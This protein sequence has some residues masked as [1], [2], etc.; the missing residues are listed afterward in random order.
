MIKKEWQAILKNK[1]FIGIMI[2][3]AFI[4]ALYNIIFLSSMW[5]PYGKIQD[6][7]VAVINLDK[8]ATLNGKTV[9]LGDDLV[10]KLAKNKA[11]DYH[12]VSEEKATS[13]IKSG[14]YFM[15]ITLPSDFSKN[16]TTLLD[17]SAKPAKIAYQT[18]KGHN[19]ISAKMSESAMEKLKAEVASNVTATYTSEIFDKFGTLKT[20]MSEAADGSQKLTDGASQLVSGSQTLT[21]G[22][23][24]LAKST[25]E[26]SDGTKTLSSA[27]KQYTDGTAKVANGLSQANSQSVDLMT[28]LTTFSQKTSEVEALVDGTAQL[29]AGL[30]TLSNQTALSD[31]EKAQIAQ[32]QTGLTS[33]NT[34]IQNFNTANQAPSELSAITGLLTAIATNATTI[35]ASNQAQETAQIAALQAT[36]AYQSLTSEQQA[37]LKSA[38]TST[39]SEVTS[40]ATQ[41][42][43]SVQNLQTV[44]SEIANKQAQSQA[45]TAQLAAA[46]TQVLPTGS[47]ALD[48]LS[49]GMNAVN[50]ALSTQIMPAS[51][52]LAIGTQELNTALTAGL[53]QLSTGV[54]QF[55]GA[56]SQL[57]DGASQLNNNS[58]TLLS[59]G[60]KLTTSATQLTSGTS[61]LASGGKQLDS[62]LTTLQSGSATLSQSLKA[63]EAQLSQQ[64]LTKTASKVISQPIKLS[65]KDTDN[66]SAN[67]VGMAPYMIAVA[68]FVGALSTNMLIG[69]SLSGGKHKNRLDWFLGKLAT[70]GVIAI[71][72]AILVN[73]AVHLLGLSANHELET[74]FFIILISL[75]FMALATFLNTAF[76]KPGAFIVLILLLLQ[77]ASSAGTY[78]LALTDKFF[79][80]LNPWLPMTYAV[81]GLRQVISLSGNVA[82]QASI[83]ILV[84]IFFAILTPFTVKNVTKNV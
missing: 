36:S 10:E 37:E 39:S 43:Q 74:F 29:N 48:T 71:A 23:D 84:A 56:I 44:L 6:L 34:A 55:S 3:L 58:A 70:N 53:G 45:A 80:T 46:A 66:A 26:F 12:F 61:Q 1:L 30:T 73:V 60:D 25:V 47:Q 72:Q 27:L 21:T 40:Q 41:T 32:L 67:G 62:A 35:I 76:G 63:A 82:V 50:A 7:P 15:V 68:L 57:N 20:G 28:G 4:P 51:A 9:N 49:S 11:L 78:P 77:L 52:Q 5:D 59:G 79:Q 33:L 2:A 18:T 8:S 69:T 42:L 38:F 64:N 19:F 54:A 14:K 65:H 22:L 83:L 17:V 16:A 24:T 75:A 31:E 81:S 13:G